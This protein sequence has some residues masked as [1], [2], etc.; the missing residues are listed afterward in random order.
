MEE[1]IKR[2]LIKWLVGLISTGLSGMGVA[3]GGAAISP[4]TINLQEG[5]YKFGAM[6]LVGFVIGVINYF[7]RS[8]LDQAL[9]GTTTTTTNTTTVVSTPD[10]TKPDNK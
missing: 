8:P 4:T 2:N 6:L 3:V 1:A 9:Y 10:P 7:Q 5:I